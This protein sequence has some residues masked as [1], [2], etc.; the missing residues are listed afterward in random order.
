[1]LFA[2]AVHMVPFPSTH[3][4][5]PLVPRDSQWDIIEKK[6]ISF[7]QQPFVNSLT[8]IVMLTKNPFFSSECLNSPIFNSSIFN[9]PVSRQLF[10]V[11]SERIDKEKL[12]LWL[13]STAYLF[14]SLIIKR[15]RRLYWCCCARMPN[16]PVFSIILALGEYP[17]TCIWSRPLRSSQL[18]TNRPQPVS[19]DP[20]I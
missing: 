6:I 7:Y 2:A 15:P 18:W 4:S 9:L 19:N 5:R 11:R 10:A 8:K 3:K 16:Y 12:V 17:P 20:L 1:M 13:F 14:L